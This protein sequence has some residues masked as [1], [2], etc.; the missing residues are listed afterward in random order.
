MT[1]LAARTAAIDDRRGEAPWRQHEYVRG[2]GVFGMPFDSGHV[3]ALRVFP[4]GSFGP[5]R[6][7]WHRDPAGAWSIRYDAPS[8]DVA[9]PRYYGPACTTVAPAAIVLTWTGPRSLRVE[10][11]EPRLTWTMTARRSA[12]LALLNP[13]M[14]SMPLSS[15][16]PPALV[17]VRERVARALGLGD[18]AL[19]GTMP[20]GHQGLLMPERMHLVDDASAVLDGTD[21]GR[22]V[23]ATDN[24]TIGGVALPARGVIAIGQAMWPVLDPDEF[25]RTRRTTIKE[26]A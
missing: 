25:D 9:C 6:S 2:W 17:R 23:R 5:N 3:L 4:E 7:V 26:D 19:Q 16:R 18:V 21:L 22:P 15:W 14:A 1:T 24:P 8:A 12:A 11:D 13:L 20:S 10:L